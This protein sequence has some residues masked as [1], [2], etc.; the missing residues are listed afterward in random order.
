[1]AKTG[2]KVGRPSKFTQ[3]VADEICERIAQG[4]SL[5]K[6]CDDKHM[7]AAKTVD[8]WLA[9]GGEFCQQYARAR[10]RQAD[11]FAE[12]LI[13]IA[14]TESDASKARNRIDARKWAASKLAPKKY[15][16]RQQIDLG[17]SVDVQHKAD[18]TKLTNEQLRQLAS[19]AGSLQMG[20][21]EPEGD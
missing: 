9:D 6:I 17:G 19:V 20:A 3:T 8:R 16:D 7:P 1:M 11:H 12:E 4:E 10:E 5:R 2:K 14:D 18:L 21:G 13:E 15:G